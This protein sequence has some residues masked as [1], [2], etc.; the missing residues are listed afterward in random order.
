MV[1]PL[2]LH[3]E[4]SRNK[5]YGP[6]LFMTDLLTQVQFLLIRPPFGTNARRKEY[7]VENNNY[8]LKK[9]E[10]YPGLPDHKS[11]TLTWPYHIL[12]LQRIH[13]HCCHLGIPR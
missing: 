1:S 2:A 4:L 3:F 12:Y 10:F 8:I 13:K 5:C 9:Q 11:G 6:R 7:I